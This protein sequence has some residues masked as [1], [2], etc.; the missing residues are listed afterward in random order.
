MSL[1]VAFLA[2]PNNIDGIVRDSQKEIVTL[3][4]SR[5]QDSYRFLSA[6]RLGNDMIEIDS[7]SSQKL[8]IGNIP[9]P[10]FEAYWIRR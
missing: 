6:Y 7:I 3:S 9:N 4:T 8:N 10:D 2:V 5:N 1:L